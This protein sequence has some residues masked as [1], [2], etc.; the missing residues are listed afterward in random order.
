MQL[1]A[2]R[3]NA[4]KSED[5][6]A[7]VDEPENYDQPPDSPETAAFRRVMEA[8]QARSNEDRYSRHTHG[9]SAEEDAP[10]ERLIEERNARIAI[11]NIEVRPADELSSSEATGTLMEE[12]PGG[13]TEKPNLGE[14]DTQQIA[15]PKR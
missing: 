3:T 6:P 15:Y 13:R 2:E 7:E 8:R 11:D 9:S 1:L 12:P 5:A 14:G 4:L 10:S